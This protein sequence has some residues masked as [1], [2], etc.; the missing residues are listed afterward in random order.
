[1]STPSFR[2]LLVATV[3][4]V[5][6]LGI[7]EFLFRWL[8]HVPDSLWPLASILSAV[9]VFTFGFLVVL[10]SAHTGL[11]SPVIGLPTLLAWA[12]YRDIAAPPPEW[13]ELG[14]HLV[15]DGS[16]YLTSYVGTWYVWLATV[17]VFAAV[18]FGFRH[19]YEIGDVRLRNLPPMPFGRR[20]LVLVS[21][22]VGGTFGIAVVGWM[23]SIGVNPTG[24][25]PVLAVTTALAA[26]VPVGAAVAR[27][28]VTPPACFLTLVVP[29][30][31]NQT[32]V[33]GEGGPVFLLLLGPLAV[34][35]AILGLLED[36][37]RSRLSGRFGGVD[38]VDG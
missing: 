28:L 34:G 9:F 25:V 20:A 10:L 7:V 3:G 30:L 5:V 26:A 8:G 31:L 24:I 33:G 18:E 29:V 1:M 12:T 35:F 19:H 16:V 2:T 27:G 36:L 22:A 17:V 11:L 4:G 6:H 23:A 32:F 14:G 15:V 38:E 13:S 21:G 37:L